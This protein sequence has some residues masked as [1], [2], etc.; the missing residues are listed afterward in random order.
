[1]GVAWWR[2]LPHFSSKEA[3]ALLGAA[4]GM[5]EVRNRLEGIGLDQYADAFDANEI[6]MDL[7]GQVDDQLLKNIGVSI[8]GHRLRIRNA[9]AEL[10]SPAC[11]RRVALHE[12]NSSPTLD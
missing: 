4:Q 12:L 7:L 2:Y 1:L 10:R 11:E 9:I 8:G 3:K 5:S 6:G